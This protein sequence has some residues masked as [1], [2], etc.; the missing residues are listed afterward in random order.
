MQR[1]ARQTLAT[2]LLALLLLLAVAAVFARSATAATGDDA[3]AR[4]RATQQR[5][6]QTQANIDA[7]KRRESALGAQVAAYDQRL[8]ALG[9]QLAAID[10]EATAVR[11]KLDRAR[12]RLEEVQRRLHAKQEELRR[13]EAELALQQDGFELRIETTYKQGEVG[14]LDVLVGANGFDDF[15]TRLGLVHEL[16]AFDNGLVGSLESARDRVDEQRRALDE[17]RAAAQEVRDELAQQ[18]ERLAALRAEAAARQAELAQARAAKA[19]VLQQVATDRRAW[20]RQ[21]DQLQAESARLAAIIA[22]GSGSGHGTGQLIW[23]V[24]GPVSSGFGWRMHPIFHVMKFHTGIDIAVGYGTPIK[25]ADGGSVIYATWMTGYGNV[26]IID[27]GRGL[28]TL[29]AHMSA[30]STSNGVTVSRGQVIGAVG[31]TGYA[32]GPH[33]HFEVRVNGNPVDPLGYLP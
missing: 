11:D 4:W 25:A 28:S 13:A 10:A 16:V 31:A 23:P 2:A 3:R 9:G 17:A 22:G 5:L 26:V 20:E 12:A 33:L 8:N 29:Y 15:V 32:T 7:A 1:T 14:Y 6:N 24:S 18:S 27:H 21:E 19:G 30:F